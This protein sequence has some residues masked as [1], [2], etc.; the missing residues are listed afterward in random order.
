MA[1]SMNLQPPSYVSETKTYEEYKRELNGW[2]LVTNVEKS[3][4]AIV[5]ALSIPDDAEGNIKQKIFAELTN[6]ELNVDDGMKK[7]LDFLDK[8]YLKDPFVEAYEKYM[9]WNGLYR[10]GSQKVE[11]FILEY[12]SVCKEAESKGIGDFE[13]IKAFKL[14]DA[15]RLDTVERQ[16]VFT[17]IDF[18]EAGEKKNIFEQMKSAIKKFKGEQSKIIQGGAERIDSVFLSENEE[19]L[20]ALGYT[21]K[22]KKLNPTN[23]RRGEHF[24]CHICKSIEHYANVCPKKKK[25][26]KTK[27]ELEESLV[28]IESSE[29]ELCLMVAE[30]DNR[31]VLDSA[32]TSTVSGKSWYNNYVKTLSRKGRK[33]L[34][35]TPSSKVFKFGDGEKKPSLKSVRLPVTI[36]GMKRTVR[37]EV[38]DAEIPLLFSLDTMKKAKMVIDFHTDE[39]IVFG[40]CVRLGR[41]SIGHYSLPLNEIFHQRYVN[42][43]NLETKDE[44]DGECWISISSEDKDEQKSALIKLHKQMGHLPIT[45]L[46]KQSG[47]WVEGMA[48]IIQKIEENCRT[49]K[50]YA[51][52]PAKPV[53]ALSRA[54]KFNEVLSLDLKF[55][56]EKIILYMIDQ[57]SR[58]T[59]G[60]F[61]KSKN[62][63]DVLD[64]IWMHWIAAGYGCP[65]YIHNDKGGEFQSDQMIELSERLG[66]K[67]SSTAGYAPHQNGINERNHAVTDNCLNK[68]KEDF[69]NMK[70]EIVLAHAV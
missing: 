52:T 58:L 39:A 29:K 23:A 25:N 35:I 31:A 4:Q 56:E 65:H 60:I 37:V 63:S 14:L 61:I 8:I 11:E 38:V 20:A 9:K 22:N 49:C 27:Q 26:Q 53:V 13:V 45:T 40:R 70:D 15:S 32:C 16:L 43:V 62:T 68:I 28:T 34:K 69:P 3:K 46:I 2:A 17:G 51:K 19:I 57:W 18:K 50:I 1:T 55:W 12:V 6:E 67:V 10:R 33:K 54:R 48:P 64:A 59:V 36:A 44:F 41:T 42:E 21:K 66:C 24:T 30:T 47:N 5:V 7:L